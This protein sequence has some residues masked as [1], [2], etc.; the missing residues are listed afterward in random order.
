MSS[1]KFSIRPVGQRSISST[2][3]F[4]PSNRSSDGGKEDRIGSASQKNSQLS[5]ADFLN[6]KLHRSSVLPSSAPVCT[7]HNLM[8][9]RPDNERGTL[10]T[11]G[12]EMPSSFPSP[13]EDSDRGAQG[14][15]WGV[16]TDVKFSIGNAFHIF[17]NVEKDRSNS[18][19][20]NEANATD[21]IDGNELGQT[22]KRKES[23][24]G[25]EDK[26]PSRKRLAV[27]GEDS[28]PEHNKR[29][30]NI[31]H[32]EPRPFYNHYKNGGGWWDD[33]ME[34]VDN[35]EVGCNDPWEGMGCTTLGG[36]NWD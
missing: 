3:L 2:F 22:R 13:G 15:K 36:I 28:K 16:D 7:L 20:I 19:N 35:K 9:N 14:E 17:K 5:L 21:V 1:R 26:T 12:K 31:A 34:G 23:S 27:L 10:L 6:T 25:H 8:L 29:R 30:L 33:N 24:K 32:K 4:R 18:D 11:Q